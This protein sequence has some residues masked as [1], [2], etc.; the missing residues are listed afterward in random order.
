VSNLESGNATSIDTRLQVVA[1][2][3]PVLTAA[4]ATKAITEWGRPAGDI[5]HL[6]FSTSSGAYMPGADVRFASILGLNPTVQRTMICFQACTGGASALLVAK[7]IAENNRGARV[8]VTCADLLSVT[9]FRATTKPTPRARSVRLFR[10]R[11]TDF[12]AGTMWPVK[13]RVWT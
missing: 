10:G 8:L 6:V 5:S 7:N 4:A 1:A 2:A 9:G 12:P 11:N 13:K 3:L